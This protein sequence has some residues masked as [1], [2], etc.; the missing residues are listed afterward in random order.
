MI[1]DYRLT[2]LYLVEDGIDQ[3]ETFSLL[4]WKIYYDPLISR[5]HNE[6]LGYQDTIPLIPTSKHIHT[7]IMA[8]M[9]DSLW[10][11]LSKSSLQKILL[12]A[13]SF[14]KFARIKV[15]LSKSVLTTNSL[16]EDRSVTF[17]EEIINIIDKSKAFKYLGT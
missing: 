12:T 8:Y 1:T 2:K 6:H 5:I 9:D 11:A 15:N 4:L 17:N 13:N 7:S 16:I 10:V 3:R 14:Y